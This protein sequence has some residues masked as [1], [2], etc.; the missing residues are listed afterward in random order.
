MINK[1]VSEAYREQ[2][3]DLFR[4]VKDFDN[5]GEVFG[6][7]SR[8][9]IRLVELGDSSLNIKS[10]RSPSFL[11]KIYYGYIGKS[12]A[13]RSYNYANYLKSIGIGTPE[14]IAFFEE[15]N[16]F[17]LDKSYYISKH[18]DVDLTYRELVEYPNWENHENILRAFT[19]FTH[20]LHENNVLFKD[21]SPG[22]TLISKV[23]DIYTFSLV[24]LNRMSFKR[25]SLEERIKNFSRLTP[26][27]EMVAVMSDEYS[28]ITKVSYDVVYNLMWYYTTD[29]QR[30]FFRKKI[31]KSKLFFTKR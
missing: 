28:K 19:R 9:T 20:L 12:K 29:F 22:N 24:D 14:P 27:Q 1:I 23:N 17:G 13:K 30:K 2:E 4:I 8:N 21:H 6:Q 31:L 18:L 3:I 26:K 25:L 10:F 15:K 7:Q 11:K 16:F 5:H